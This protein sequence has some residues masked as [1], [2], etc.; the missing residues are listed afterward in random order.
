MSGGTGAGTLQ[1]PGPVHGN[2]DEMERNA[3]PALDE[4][5]D[6]SEFAPAINLLRPTQHPP[7]PPDQHSSSATLTSHLP[8]PPFVAAGAT[9]EV[10]DWRT[11][12]RPLPDVHYGPRWCRFCRINKPDRTH[13]CRH[14][15]TCIMQF[16]RQYRFIHIRSTG[17]YGRQLRHQTIVY[18]LVAVSAG[19]I[20]R[21]VGVLCRHD[22]N[23]YMQFF[24]TFV[25]WA[26]LYCFYILS[27]LIVYL[28]QADVDGQVIGLIAV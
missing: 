28:V 24:M 12:E 7:S 21:W 10:P 23:S 16:D 6:P 13:H 15:G 18:G 1:S 11:V 22:Y 27:I 17:R 5:P 25:F 2:H 20:T 19:Q 3:V 26:M 9:R 8:P 4:A 14:C